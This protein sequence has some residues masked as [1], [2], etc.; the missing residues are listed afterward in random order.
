MRNIRLTLSYDGTNYV[1][2]QVQPNGPSV[3][4]AVEQ[5]VCKLT[6][7]TVRLV[8]A[9]RTDSGVHALEQVANFVTKTAITCEKLQTGLQNFLADDVIIRDVSDVDAKFHATYSVKWKRY[10]YVIFNNR[11]SDPFIQKYTWQYAAALDAAAMHDAAQVLLGTHDFRCFESHFPNKATS[12]RTVIES[13]V[14]RCGGWP[15]WSRSE[16][17]VTANQKPANPHSRAPGEQTGEFVR[18]D[19][20][21]DGFLY[22]MV[23][24]IVGTLLKVGRHQWTAEDVRRIIDTGDRSQAGETAPARGLYLVHVEY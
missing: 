12:V 4:A 5:A 14:E 8:A 10:R 19:I 2:W 1:G 23:R 22:N 3:Q 7:E 20:A 21:A 11:V 6:G 15:L 24:A 9:G 17:P 13:R 16:S 18:L